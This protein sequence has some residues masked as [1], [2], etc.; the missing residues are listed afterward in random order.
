MNPFESKDYWKNLGMYLLAFPVVAYF[1]FVGSQDEYGSIIPRWEDI[2]MLVGYMGL[3]GMILSSHLLAKRRVPKS[4]EDLQEIIEG[5][6]RDLRAL[7]A[8][9]QRKT[10]EG[11]LD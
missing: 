10:G 8:K 9:D 5:A 1:I 4:R 6:T 7:D 11:A 2:R 3:A